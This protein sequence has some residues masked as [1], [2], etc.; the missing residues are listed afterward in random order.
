MPSARRIFAALS[1][2]AAAALGGAGAAA[3]Q[4]EDAGW[5]YN[6][7]FAAHFDHDDDD[8]DET[9]SPFRFLDEQ[10]YAELNVT[11]DR[12]PSP[13]SRT[14]ISFVGLINESDYRSQ[15]DGVVVER[16]SIS[17]ESG[18]GS[19]PYRATLGDYYAAISY[20]TLQQS[21][22]GASFELQPVS[23]GALRHSVVGFT[24]FRNRDYHDVNL[25]D[26]FY[27]GAS[28]LLDHG[29]T[30]RASVNA[31]YAHQDAGATFRNPDT[32]NDQVTLSAAANARF[33]LGAFD[34][35]LEG[36][37]GFFDGD[38]ADV[39]GKSDLG[40]FGELTL[41][42]DESR[43]SARLRYEDYGEH[44]QPLGALSIGDRRSAEAHLSWRSAKG[45][46]VRARAQTYE[47]ARSTDRRRDRDI[48]GVNLSGSLFRLAGEPVSGSIDAFHQDIDSP[49]DALNRESQTLNAYLSRRLG[50]RANIR[51]TAFLENVEDQSARADDTV[52]ASA[53]V[54]IGAP[55]GLSGFEGDLSVGIKARHI[56]A[57]VSADTFEAQPTIALDVARGPHR[58]RLDYDFLLQDR[59][60]ALDPLFN[61]NDVEQQKAGFLYAYS[62]GDHEFGLSGEIVD[63]RIEDAED[64]TAYRIGVF[65]RLSL[66]GQTRRRAGVAPRPVYEAPPSLELDAPAAAQAN[67]GEA[68][69]LDAGGLLGG[70]APG[71]TMADAA[72]ALAEATGGEPIARDQGLAADG[73]FVDGVFGRQTLL[74]QD[75]FGGVDR[76]LLAV[77]LAGAG[78][79][80]IEEAYA[81]L[82]AA[83]SARL[84]EPSRVQDEG[85]RITL[86]P[87]LESGAEPA[88]QIAWTGPA[89][90]VLSATLAADAGG[91]PVILVLHRR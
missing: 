74:V 7:E 48:L 83:L 39:A 58:L 80:E 38:Y 31:V 53:G 86:D 37:L 82:A 30:W 54:S 3:A 45:L 19:V 5:R 9:Q 17:H 89:G 33:G 75:R 68:S 22:K 64:A 65:W 8:G 32:D 60:P 10:Y 81:E 23:S 61:I 15:T 34:A 72:A 49:V 14:R 50:E 12:Q 88:R 2:G 4:E 71:D 76:V 47:D 13:Y 55:V 1:A 36:E 28:W 21:L 57:D 66:Q 51:V 46:F 16:F 25:L 70:V 44:Y 69:Y 85:A 41:D 26:E 62:V 59:D 91:Q 42:H 6:G 43:V 77:N 52:T 90:D 56:S 84:G 79:A 18:E 24:G 29:R 11:A 73:V 67:R 35:E 27:A 87:F 63:R 78:A 40:L 20:R